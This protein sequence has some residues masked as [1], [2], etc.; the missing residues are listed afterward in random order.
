MIWFADAFHFTKVY[1]DKI[2]DFIYSENADSNK[3]F[4]YKLDK[5]LIGFYSKFNLKKLQSLKKEKKFNA[6]LDKV[7]IQ[8]Q[9]SCSK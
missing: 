5:N 4:G 8:S 7:I 2:M 9:E 6:I 1:G 3:N